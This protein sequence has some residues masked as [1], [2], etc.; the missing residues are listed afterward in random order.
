LS[1]DALESRL[2]NA[3]GRTLGNL[4][5]RLRDIVTG[6]HDDGGILEMDAYN[7]Q[8]IDQN[9]RTLRNKIQEAGL[10][11][12]LSEQRDVLDSLLD[13]IREEAEGFGLPDVFAPAT[14]KSIQMLIDGS[15]ADILRVMDK[16]ADDVAVHLRSAIVGGVKRTDLLGSIAQT[17]GRTQRQA[18]TVLGTSL[19]SFHR[20]VTITHAKENDV[21]EFG[22]VGPK[23]DITREWCRR[24]VGRRGTVA[25]IEATVN[26]WGRAKQPGPA[27]V[28]GGGWGCR[29][30]WIPIIGE[31]Q[32]KKY[33][34]AP[35]PTGSIKW[36]GE[37]DF[38][39]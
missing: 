17:M 18:K 3:W 31:R 30:D 8:Q 34:P 28:F 7:V 38:G 13:E 39:S 33:K 1:I 5:L 4:E 26:E 24:W 36:E 6:L 12:A 16:A 9:L 32:R 10:G 11:D 14:D 25:Q 2:W 21:E 37:E 29:H 15:E 27:S 22:Y 20:Q 19:Q 35:T 23:D